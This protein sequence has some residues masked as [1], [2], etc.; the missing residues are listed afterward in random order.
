MSLS[1]NNWLAK[2]G[3][4]ATVFLAA[5]TGLLYVVGR[6]HQS[7]YLQ[8]W[9]GESDFF[10]NDIYN[11]LVDG[12]IVL[13]AGM[14][15]VLIILIVIVIGA[16]Q[17]TA[18]AICLSKRE[19]SRKTANWLRKKFGSKKEEEP[20]SEPPKLLTDIIS[21]AFTSIMIGSLLLAA[22]YA[23]HRLIIFSSEQGEKHAAKE[24]EQYSQSTSKGDQKSLFSKLRTYCI[25]TTQRNALLLATDRNT[26]ALYF[27]KTKTAAESVEII[28]ATR[29]TCIKATRNTAP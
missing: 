10:A 18:I 9:G 4:D 7:G 22:L 14:M 15:Y 12:T 29:I 2:V 20:E 6:Y 13:S 23:F 8:K 24:Y 21:I 27:P 3:I 1:E 26:Y 25:D 28:A 16:L 19:A 11:S 17:Y 5:A